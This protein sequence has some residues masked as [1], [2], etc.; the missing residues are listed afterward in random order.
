MLCHN[1]KTMPKQQ[2]VPT[3]SLHALRSL[4]I[5][6]FLQCIAIDFDTSYTLINVKPFIP[7]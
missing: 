4:V 1:V 5:P 6:F 3:G 2:Y 7:F